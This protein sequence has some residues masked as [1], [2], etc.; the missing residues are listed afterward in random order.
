MHTPPVWI[1]FMI[2]SAVVVLVALGVGY[3]R[4]STIALSTLL[5][6]ALCILPSTYFGL[7]AFRGRRQSADAGREVV[8]AFY[9]AERDK[10]ILTLVGFALVFAAIRPLDPVVLFVSYGLCILLQWFL[11]ARLVR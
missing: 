9:N 11:A 1:I 8:K 10:F 2:Q 5:G 3:W 6:G 7:R 4:D